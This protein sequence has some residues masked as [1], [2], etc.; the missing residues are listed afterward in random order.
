MN[1]NHDNKMKLF[2]ATRASLELLAQAAS[3]WNAM[4]RFRKDRER[5]KKYCYGDQWE[6]LVD[7]DGEQMVEKDYIK[8]MGSVPLKNNLIRRL[9]RNVMGVYRSSPFH[10]TCVAR[11]PEEEGLAATMT[12]L[13]QANLQVNRIEEINARSL[14]EFLISGL[15][16]H[17]KWYGFRNGLDECWTDYVSPDH[18]F[19]DSETRDFRG[20]DVGM[21]GEIHDLSIQEVMALYASS[22]YDCHLLSKIYGQK[23]MTGLSS[24]LSQLGYS[25][26]LSVD[27]I[28]CESM[29]KC[30]VIEI[31][32]K[33]V[34]PVVRIHLRGE[35]RV[36]TVEKEHSAHYEGDEYVKK[37][38]MQEEWHCYYLAP[39]GELLSHSRSPYSHGSHPYVW[40]AYPFID[41]EIHSFVADVIDQQRYTNRLITLYDWIM[42]TSAKGVLMVPEDSLGSMT[43]QEFSDQ[44]SRFNGVIFYRPRPGSPPPHQISTNSTNIGISELLNL[45]LK[46]FED[47]SGVNGALQGKAAYS[48]MSG[49][50]FSQQTFN[51]TLSLVDIMETFSKFVEE[52]V[53]RS[54]Q[55]IRQYYDSSRIL[56]ISGSDAN[57]STPYTIL[58]TDYDLSIAN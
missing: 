49:T 20:W 12:S 17:R 7:V 21:V 11:I 34:R 3:C 15:V 33:E 56:Q 43:P 54:L 52:S 26:S 19:L 31:W 18:F 6:D 30:R 41:G 16:V 22:P 8:K 57:P 4:H 28:G 42:R 51:A 29:G 45:Q 38:D 14:E 5:C 40:K 36:V 48:G 10:P 55:N 27:F 50:M 47:I 53:T 46:L 35:G 58:T 32:R 1:G 9:V 2:T 44:W 24:Q 37:W 39:T 13:L 25:D 23:E